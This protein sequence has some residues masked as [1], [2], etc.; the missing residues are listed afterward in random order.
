MKGTPEEG[1]ICDESGLV[2]CEEEV[3]TR[4]KDYFVTLLES[5]QTNNAQVLEYGE[6]PR[7]VN[8]AAECTDKIS[9]E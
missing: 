6:A 5:E 4:W 8:Q 2:L 1:R 3:R 9:V 7:Q